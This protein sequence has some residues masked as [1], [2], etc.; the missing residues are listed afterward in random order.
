[1]TLTIVLLIVALILL[2]LRAF[3]VS[4]GRVDLGWLGLAVYVLAVL[5]GGVSFG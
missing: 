3:G 1:M 5:L 4:S 2:A